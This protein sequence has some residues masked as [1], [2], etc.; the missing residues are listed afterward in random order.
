MVNNKI[1]KFNIPS[2]VNDDPWTMGSLMRTYVLFYC[3][4]DFASNDRDALGDLI[5]FNVKPNLIRITYTNWARKRERDKGVPRIRHIHLKMPPVHCAL[6]NEQLNCWNFAKYLQP[7][8]FTSV[9]AVCCSICNSFMFCSIFNINMYG[10]WQTIVNFN[11]IQKYRGICAIY[12]KGNERIFCLLEFEISRRRKTNRAIIRIKDR[13][14]MIAAIK[15]RWAD[16]NVQI[17]IV[18]F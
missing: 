6:H 5:V 3:N 17:E 1:H 11:W 9:F 10:V 16:S 2:T 7:K 15:L 18:F 8:P 13:C 4:I 14:G 12:L